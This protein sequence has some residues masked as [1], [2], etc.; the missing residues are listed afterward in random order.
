MFDAGT[1]A[2]APLAAGMCA[3]A[4]EANPNLSWRDLQHIVVMSANP[5]PLQRESGWVLN[6]ARRKVSSRWMIDPQALYA[7]YTLYHYKMPVF[8]SR[9]INKS[10]GS[11][12]ALST[13]VSG[14]DGQDNEVHYLE[15]VQCKVSLSFFPRGN[16]KLLLVSPSGTP[17]TLLAYRPKDEIAATLDDWPFL[18]VHFWGEDPRGQWTLR[19]LNNG[20]KKVDTDGVFI[21]WQLYFYGTDTKPV[22][23]KPP[24]LQLYKNNQD[25]I[26]ETDFYKGAEHILVRRAHLRVT[27]TKPAASATL[28]TIRA[29]V[30]RQLQTRHALP[31]DRI[32]F[33]TT[34]NASN[35]RAKFK[36]S[37]TNSIYR[38]VSFSTIQFELSK[39]NRHMLTLHCENCAFLQAINST[40]RRLERD[41]YPRRILNFGNNLCS[42]RVRGWTNPRVAILS[43][44]ASTEVNHPPNIRLLLPSLS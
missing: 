37:S 10:F 29:T 44:R 38:A 40:D 20:R 43:K 21:K 32:S 6:G 30:A 23:L 41:A 3:L 14:C 5:R 17:S 11:E 7:T 12:L 22:N 24:S 35:R 34:G 27:W 2:S 8:S 19:I 39:E 18:S 25:K 9:P 4:L 36:I 28:V 16:L 13:N 33:S 1:S 42:I 26:T 15:H 31:A